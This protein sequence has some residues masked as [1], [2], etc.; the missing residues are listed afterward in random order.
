MRHAETTHLHTSISFSKKLAIL[1]HLSEVSCCLLA[2]STAAIR[3]LFHESGL[4]NDTRSCM[5]SPYACGDGDEVGVS[6]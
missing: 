1:K 6:F 4:L 2:E 5:P 3:K